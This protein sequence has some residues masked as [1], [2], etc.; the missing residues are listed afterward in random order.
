MSSARMRGEGMDLK[1]FLGEITGASLTD[2][3]S[4]VLKQLIETY[5]QA[6]QTGLGLTPVKRQTGGG[7]TYS[8]PIELPGDFSG[9]DLTVENQE[10]VDL[11]GDYLDLSHDGILK[12]ESSAY[13]ALGL[14]EPKEQQ[15]IKECQQQMEADAEKR[16]DNLF[17]HDSDNNA[18]H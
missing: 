1:S 3:Q 16:F 13:S 17:G 15:Q 11:D 7:R 12:V 14:P 6:V 5:P 18:I 9:F 2:F 10:I 4:A 8:L